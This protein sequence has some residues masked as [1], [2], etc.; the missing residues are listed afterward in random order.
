MVALKGALARSE[1]GQSLVEF[2]LAMP[3]LLLL[4]L[5]IADLGRAFYYTVT[6]SG[7]ARE[8]A[9]FAAINPGASSGTVAQHACDVTGFRPFGSACP[10]EVTV[11]CLSGCPTNGADSEVRVTYAFSLISGYLVDRVFNVNPIVLRA[12]ARFPGTAAP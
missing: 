8:A 5:G 12:D 1:R 9:A 11:T 2:A 4:L 7:A 3:F 10:A 6:I